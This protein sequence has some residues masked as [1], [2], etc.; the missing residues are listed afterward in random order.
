MEDDPD[1]LNMEDKENWRPRKKLK[2]KLSKPMTKANGPSEEWR[3]VLQKPGLM[4]FIKVK[5]EEPTPVEEWIEKKSGESEEK[6]DIM[7]GG[8]GSHLVESSHVQMV[9][10]VLDGERS[11]M[12]T[13]NP[14]EFCSPFHELENTPVL[15]DVEVNKLDLSQTEPGWRSSS[16]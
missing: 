16:C 10:K 7:E 15:P 11:L 9:E 8:C 6:N 12:N 2:L 4:K 1:I 3:V 13:M 14:L 5:S